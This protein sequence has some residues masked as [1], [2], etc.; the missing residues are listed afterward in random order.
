M[1]RIEVALLTLRRLGLAGWDRRLRAVPFV[2]VD[3]S[4][5]WV[6]HS[7]YVSL[8]CNRVPFLRIISFRVSLKILC[9]VST[10][11]LISRLQYSRIP[12]LTTLTRRLQA[13]PSA[14]RISQSRYHAPHLFDRP[15][16]NVF[17]SAQSNILEFTQSCFSEHVRMVTPFFSI[18]LKKILMYLPL[19]TA[20]SLSSASC[21][22]NCVLYVSCTCW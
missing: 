1:R 17:P 21:G 22:F 14:S 7:C 10:R 6:F 11:D 15:L 19:H 16:L 9:S 3:G 18:R 20:H 13:R 2:Y 8:P 4:W 12:I 5:W